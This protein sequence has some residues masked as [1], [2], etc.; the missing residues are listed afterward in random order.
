MRSSSEHSVR[1]VNAVSS[2][3]D[4]IGISTVT[5][6]DNVKMSKKEE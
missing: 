6:C 3:E 1:Q 5:I 2:D 4:G